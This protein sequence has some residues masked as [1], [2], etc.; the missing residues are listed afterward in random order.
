M[1]IRK[2]GLKSRVDSEKRVLKNC[3]RDKLAIINRN[4][5]VGSYQT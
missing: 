2:S 1:L 4:R 3:S 5:R